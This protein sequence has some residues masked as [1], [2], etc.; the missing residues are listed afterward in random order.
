MS[1]AHLDS[2]RLAESVHGDT[3]WT[4]AEAAHL[5]RCAECRLELD[6]LG[7][8]RRLASRQLAGL[9]PAQVAPEVLHRLRDDQALRKRRRGQWL[10]GLAAAAAVILAVS[11][12]MPRGPSIPDDAGLA[13]YSTVSVL[14]ELDGLSEPQLEEVLQ[15][16]PQATEALDHVEMAPLSDLSA[17]D[18]ERVLRSMEEE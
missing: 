14:H 12:G 8:A 15:S 17:S 16:I 3:A 4:T 5:A 9:D 7:A 13:A 6:I 2:D 1:G 11:L 18:L 10:V